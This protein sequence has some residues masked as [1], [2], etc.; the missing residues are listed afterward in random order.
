[1]SKDFAILPI[2]AIRPNPEQPRQIFDEDNLASLAESIALH[3]VLNP[4][5]VR[6]PFNESGHEYYVLIDGE[7]RLRASKIAK[8]ESIPARILASEVDPGDPGFSDHL[9]LAVIANLQRADLNPIEEGESFKKMMN[10]G[11]TVSSI[12]RIAGVTQPVI[13]MRLSLLKFEPAIRRLFAEGRLPLDKR[14]IDSLELLPDGIRVQA[15]IKFANNN[16]TGK[17]IEATCGRILSSKNFQ[18]APRNYIKKGSTPSIDLSGVDDIPSLKALGAAGIVPQW[19][20]I[21]TAAQETCDACPLSD[22]ASEEICGTCPVVD[23]LK[24]LVK[25]AS[26][27]LAVSTSSPK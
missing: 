16:A 11:W 4:I 8:K 9:E 27:T 1:M 25:V 15:A 22:S 13:Y 12:S 5:V 10:Q 2:D 14:A 20:V 3:D 26:M 24:R 17:R 19:S 21:K 7:R 18:K 6:G 23:L